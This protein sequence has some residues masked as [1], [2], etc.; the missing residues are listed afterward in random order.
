MRI[1][2]WGEC[3]IVCAMYLG[4]HYDKE[5]IGAQ[6]IAEGQQLELQYTQ[7]VLQRLRKGGIIESSRGPRG[8]Y[9]LASPPSEITLK[10]ILYAVEGDTF[11]LIC[12]YAPLHPQAHESSCCS[13]REQC[14]LHEVWKDLRAV[15]DS[16]LESRT[17]VELIESSPEVN[18]ITKIGKIK[19]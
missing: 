12:D 16:F 8:G 1:T 4:Q 19:E 15:I 18:I 13:T 17:L 3:G 5:S 6:E 9:R 14:T 2:K 11:E 7:Q 10:S